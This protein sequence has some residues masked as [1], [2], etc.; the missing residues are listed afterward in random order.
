MAAVPRAVR[1]AEQARSPVL[2]VS[3]A[4][5]IFAINDPA[6]IAEL[7]A[8]GSRLSK[9]RGILVMTPHYGSRR[10]EVGATGRG[11]AMY[12]LPDGIK[13][14]VPSGLTYE[15]PPNDA[16]AA[17]VDALLG[18]GTPLARGNRGGFDHT[19][20]M[21]LKCIF[22]DADV[23]MLELAYPYVPEAE[24]FAI[25][26]KLAPLRDEGVLFV[27]SGGMTHNLAAMELGADA[28]AYAREFDVWAS[29][30]IAA[31]DA[32]ALI[33]WRA[34]APAANLAH[35][36]DGG[37]YRVLLVAMGV[38]L[39]EGTARVSFPVTG[40]EATMSKRSVELA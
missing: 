14:L 35:P 33:D 3:H 13:R 11:F 25:G 1:A 5:P 4:A 20:W 34:K 9:P 10:L 30:R 29:G 37:H 26:R 18:A 24:A 32:D 8:W 2:Y 40:F 31:H 7:R 19:T 12:D 6:R 23:P 16:L 21:P 27:A 17:R 39:A 22:P 15:T 36:D 38:A 28:P